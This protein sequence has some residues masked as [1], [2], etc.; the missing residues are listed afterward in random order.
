MEIVLHWQTPSRDTGSLGGRGV[1]GGIMVAGGQTVLVG[2]VSSVLTKV[3]GRREG[4]PLGRR[5]CKWGAGY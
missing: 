2:L 5:I 1:T 3:L 4:G